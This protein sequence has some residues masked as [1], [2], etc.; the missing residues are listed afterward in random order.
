MDRLSFAI[1][2]C[3]FISIVADCILEDWSI[4]PLLGRFQSVRTMKL[5]NVKTQLTYNQLKFVHEIFNKFTHLNSAQSNIVSDCFD[6]RT[7]TLL[8][9]VSRSVA[10][11]HHTAFV[12][13]D[14]H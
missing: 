6:R 2:E 5:L 13:F 4:V 9:R 10:Q 3:L 1:T 8:R 12:S 7:E 14:V 11:M